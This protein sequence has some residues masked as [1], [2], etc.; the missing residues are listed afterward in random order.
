MDTLRAIGIG[1]CSA[2]KKTLTQ[3]ELVECK[4]SKRDS[5]K[6]ERHSY[7]LASLTS[8]DFS[9]CPILQLQVLAVSQC[10]ILSGF[11]HW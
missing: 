5:W 7:G 9:K 4:E 3:L 8:Y 1:R 2:K 11:F 10:N 6:R